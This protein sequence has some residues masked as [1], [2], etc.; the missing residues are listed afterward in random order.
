MVHLGADA[1][2]EH[3]SVKVLREEF[4]AEPRG[5]A[6]GSTYRTV[7]RRPVSQERTASV[8]VW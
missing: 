2:G 3:V 7:L 4:A 6:G 5:G 1:G 8:K